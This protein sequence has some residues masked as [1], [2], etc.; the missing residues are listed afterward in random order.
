[1]GSGTEGGEERPAGSRAARGGVCAASRLCANMLI[2][3][4]SCLAF[5]GNWLHL[6]PL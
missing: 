3:F 4:L 5:Q 2:C 6:K 1:M